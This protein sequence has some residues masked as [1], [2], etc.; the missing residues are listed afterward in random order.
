MSAVGTARVPQ[1][2]KRKRTPQ[3]HGLL[4]T[5][6]DDVEKYS[7]SRRYLWVLT[8]GSLIS[9]ACLAMSQFLFTASSPW[10]WLTLPLLAFIIADYLI[11]LYLDGLS[12]DF[13]IKGHKRLVRKW[14]PAGVPERGHLPAG[15]R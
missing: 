3:S 2:R 10:F 14:Q 1:N 5:P 9:F 13:D 7:Y 8:V 11:S 12:K 4:P 15:V 6:P